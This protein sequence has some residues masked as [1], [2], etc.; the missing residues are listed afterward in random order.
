MVWSFAAVLDRVVNIEAVL[1]TKHL[2]YPHSYG[3]LRR[4]NPSVVDRFGTEESESEHHV[5]QLV[6]LCLR[7]NHRLR[8]CDRVVDSKVHVFDLPR[9]LQ[10]VVEAAGRSP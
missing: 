5:R 9:W 2:F 4:R 7:V 6:E 10:L 1:G 3:V 8:G